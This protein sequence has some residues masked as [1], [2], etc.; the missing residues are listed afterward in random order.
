MKSYLLSAKDAVSFI[1]EHR[2]SF[3][4]HKRDNQINGQADMIDMQL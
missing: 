3:V 4:E 2:K 1:V